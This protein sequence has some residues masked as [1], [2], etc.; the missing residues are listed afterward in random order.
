MIPQPSSYHVP[1]I[2]RSGCAFPLAGDDH[3]VGAGPE[4]GLAAAAKRLY[5]VGA[6]AVLLARG[7]QGSCDRK[8][9]RRTPS[10]LGAV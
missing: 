5:E 6:A 4:V 8:G 9:S 1:P 7:S 3:A 2:R 10:L